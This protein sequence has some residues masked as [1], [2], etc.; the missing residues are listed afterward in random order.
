EAFL[1]NVPAGSSITLTNNGSIAAPQGTAILVGANASG[2]PSVTLN[3]VNSGNIVGGAGTAVNFRPFSLG[4]FIQSAG[5]IDGTIRFSQT[6]LN[7]TGGAINGSILDQ[8][9][10]SGSAGSSQG[11][12]G[13]INFDLGTGSFTTN[14][15]ISVGAI[16]V[17]SGTLVLGND[18]YVPGGS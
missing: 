7:V 5:R 9:P 10:A 8:T 11:R 18:V 12:G 1:V 14:G 15:D 3:L 2:N 17:R 13:L 16:N 4:T 6:V